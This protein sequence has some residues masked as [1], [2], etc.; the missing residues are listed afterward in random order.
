[1]DATQQA[2]A[3][4]Q[5]DVATFKRQVQVVATVKDGR[6]TTGAALTPGGSPGAITVSSGKIIAVQQAT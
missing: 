3:D 5:R 2:I 1:M 4:L 6:Y